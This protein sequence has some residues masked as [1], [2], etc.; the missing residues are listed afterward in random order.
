MTGGTQ[1]CRVTPFDKPVLSLSKGS[2]LTRPTR[3][4]Q[5]TRHEM[6]RLQRPKTKTLDPR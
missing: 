6:A 5:R 1:G 2:G 4:L 3:L